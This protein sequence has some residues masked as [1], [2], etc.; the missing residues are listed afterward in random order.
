MNNI[1][2]DAIIAYTD[3]A[4]S[5]NPGPGGFGILLYTTLPNGTV[6]SK[7]VQGSVPNTTNNRMELTAVIEGLKLLRKPNEVYIYSDSEYV[8]K[9]ITSWVPDWKSHNWK[10]KEKNRYSAEIVN[11]DLWQE[12][13]ELVNTLR[14]KGYTITF[15]KVTGHSNNT[16]NDIADGLAKAGVCEAKEGKSGF[17]IL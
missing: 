2:K 14:S 15:N 12:L 8:I 13:D 1:S 7:R 4:C 10:R 3:G 5:G 16:D 11:L 6:Y 17:T 9:G